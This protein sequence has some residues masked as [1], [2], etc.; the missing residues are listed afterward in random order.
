MPKINNIDVSID[1]LETI[2]YMVEFCINNGL[3]MGQDEG[4]LTFEDNPKNNKKSI[5]RLELE[6]FCK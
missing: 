3:C 6:K 2:K 1:T 4:F 5:E